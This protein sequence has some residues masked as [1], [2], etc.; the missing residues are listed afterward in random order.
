M[1]QL[2]TNYIYPI[3]GYFEL[4]LPLHPELHAKAIALNSGRFCLEYLLRCRKYNKVYVPY[5]TCD[6]AVE[7]IIK[8]GIIYEFYH[9]D[10]AYRIID[11]IKL[12][13][14]E[15]L[16]Y[17]NY[18]GLQNEYCNKLAEKYG[19]QLILDYT[20]VFFSKPIA[21]IDTFYSCRKYFGVPD[22]GYLYSDVVADLR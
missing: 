7:P 6:T 5:F 3:G 8:L 16:L 14:D 11:D 13:E 2:Q 4:E 21:G 18:W 12:A 10:K 17:T 1:K 19:N 9:I 15:A 20:Q 22:G